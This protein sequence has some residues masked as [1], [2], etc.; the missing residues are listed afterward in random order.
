M[1]V[2][3]TVLCSVELSGVWYVSENVSYYVRAHSMY[4][5]IDFMHVD[6]FFFV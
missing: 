1:V 6:F 3:M 4:D 2:D 5:Y